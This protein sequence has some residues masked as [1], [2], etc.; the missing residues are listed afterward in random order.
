M[1]LGFAS[2]ISH[3]ILVLIE[4]VVILSLDFITPILNYNYMHFIPSKPT[5]NIPL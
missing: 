3:K 5:Q 4:N 1:I 2:K